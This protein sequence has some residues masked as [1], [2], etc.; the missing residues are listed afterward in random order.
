MN[1]FL[2]IYKLDEMICVLHITNIEVNIGNFLGAINQVTTRIC[3]PED[4]DTSQ[5]IVM[6]NMLRSR[7]L[8]RKIQTKDWRVHR[9]VDTEGIHVL[10]SHQIVRDPEQQRH[11]FSR[12][13]H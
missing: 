7:I 2:I 10:Q 13:M 11:S 9:S 6:M 8:D 12:A 3:F 1:G 4:K 5:P